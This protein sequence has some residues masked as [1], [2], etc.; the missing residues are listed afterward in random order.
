MLDNGRSFPPNLEWLQ[1]IKDAMPIDDAPAADL[2]HIVLR[3][4]NVYASVQSKLQTDF[5]VIAHEAL[6]L[7]EDL[8]K[9]KMQLPESWGYKL[10]Q[11]SDETALMYRGVSHRYRDFWT[12]RIYCHY[13]W[14]RIL[15][16]ELLLTHLGS[17]GNEDNLQRTR[18]LD[19]ISM[20]AADICSS[21]SIQ[22]DKSTLM[23]EAT[24]NGVPAVSGCFLPLFPLAIAGSA[25]GVPNELHNWVVSMLEF[26]GHGKGV[27]QALALIEPMKLLQEQWKVVGDGPSHCSLL[28]GIKM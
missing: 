28:L 4:T 6:L 25:I 9:W 12:A 11:H 10:E 1:Q 27:N 19:V 15:V 7:D 14:C 3:F 2:A 22:F 20:Q 23:E 16:N 5:K 13:R 8:E 21:V 18:S 24:R 17:S 26:I